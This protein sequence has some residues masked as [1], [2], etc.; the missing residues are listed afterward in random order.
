MRLVLA[1]NVS[2]SLDAALFNANAAVPGTSPAGILNGITPI[3]ASAAGTPLERMAE[4]IGAIA[5]VIAQ[6][7]GSN[8]GAVIV[9][10]PAQAVVLSMMA[11]EKLPVGNFNVRRTAGRH[12]DRHRRR[13]TGDGGRRTQ[14][15]GR[16]RG[17]ASLDDAPEEIVGA[18]GVLAAPIRSAFQTDLRFILPAR[19]SKAVAWVQGAGW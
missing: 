4:D 8:G 17:Y 10:A 2:A 11:E 9:A 12:R 7:A 15:R 19:S 14:E 5:E 13:G 18:G 3:T 6:A 1:E 16:H